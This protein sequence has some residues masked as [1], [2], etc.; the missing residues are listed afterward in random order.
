MESGR[1]EI[2]VRGSFEKCSKRKRVEAG[3][4]MGY[5]R[6][7]VILLY[8]EESREWRETGRLG[9]SEEKIKKN[10]G[11]RNEGEN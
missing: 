3:G 5:I 2:C 1:G 6:T 7:K 8:L 10:Y 9:K 4:K 11:N